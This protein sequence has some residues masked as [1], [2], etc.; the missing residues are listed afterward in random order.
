M[1]IEFF[2]LR[3]LIFVADFALLFGQIWKPWSRILSSPA[4]HSSASPSTNTPQALRLSTAGHVPGPRRI[5]SFACGVTSGP[6][7]PPPSPAEGTHRWS[8]QGG[9]MRIERTGAEPRARPSMSRGWN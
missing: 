6:K 9:H 5:K 4:E 2:F 3:Y 1:T 7:L 8:D